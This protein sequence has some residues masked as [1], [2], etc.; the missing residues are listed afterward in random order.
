MIRMAMA[1]SLDQ[2]PAQQRTGGDNGST[3]GLDLVGLHFFVIF[4]HQLGPT[5][6]SWSVSHHVRLPV[7]LSVCLRHPAPQGARPL[8]K[9]EGLS[10]ALRSHD[11]I[12][13]SH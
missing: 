5:G 2:Q 10:L 8:V 7:C 4:F 6:P 3:W 13:A 9:V 12:T 1:L 11:Q